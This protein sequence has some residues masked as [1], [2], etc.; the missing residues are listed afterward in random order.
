MATKN[1]ILR[2]KKA[3]DFVVS[4]FGDSVSFSITPE[5]QAVITRIN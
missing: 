5:R 4:S 1:E 2:P 3:V